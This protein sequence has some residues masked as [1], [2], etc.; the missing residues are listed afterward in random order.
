MKK[1]AILPVIS[2]VCLGVTAISG[3]AIS[4]ETQNYIAE[5]VVIVAAAGSAI[6][7][8]YKDHKKKG[9]VE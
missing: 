1:T 9:D 3:H 5:I 4:E 2:V 7:G 6:W 8:I